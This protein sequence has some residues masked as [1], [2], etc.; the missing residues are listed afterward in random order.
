VSGAPYRFLR[1]AEENPETLASAVHERLRRDIVRAAFRPGQKLLLRELCERYAI[2]LAPL[3]EALNRLASEDLVVQT[4]Q[5]GFR[6]APVSEAQLD[7]LVT[8]RCRIEEICLRESIALGDAGWEEEVTLAFRRLTG[9]RRAA[10]ARAP[11]LNPTW[12]RAHKA[13]HA[14]LLAASP[15][16]ILRNLCGQLFIA[17]DRYRHLARLPVGADARPVQDEHRAILDAALARDAEAAALLLGAH[18][19]RTAEMVRR[20]L[21]ETEG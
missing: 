13:F 12:E 4:D 16:L 11:L 20:F 2:G 18:Y 15:S 6:V 7:D 3:R 5:R 1:A 9:L 19:R 10:G 14:T 17:A 21:P 8:T